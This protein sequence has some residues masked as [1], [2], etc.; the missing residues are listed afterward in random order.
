MYS[1]VSRSRGRSKFQLS[2]LRILSTILFL[3][4]IVHFTVGIY[5]Y[6]IYI[7][8]YIVQSLQIV[9]VPTSPSG[10]EYYNNQ[11]TN[12]PLTIQVHETVTRPA[13]THAVFGG[14][15]SLSGLRIIQTAANTNKYTF[16]PI[17]LPRFFFFFLER[18]KNYIVQL[19]L[20]RLNTDR[21]VDRET[22]LCRKFLSLSLSLLK[23]KKRR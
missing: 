2:G 9:F 4:S 11:K 18:C 15:F 10:F 17:A 12:Y 5:T 22:K 19:Y 3:H 1:L 20:L 7:Y 8:L 21:R 6:N 13:P 23:K 16:N 14:L